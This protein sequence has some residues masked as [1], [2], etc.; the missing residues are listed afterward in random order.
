MPY[1]VIENAGYE[2]GNEVREFSKLAT[3][4]RWM[5]RWY[6]NGEKERLHVEIA[7]VLPNGERTYEY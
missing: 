4:I 3:A 6:A 5:E 7:K 2:G 1:A